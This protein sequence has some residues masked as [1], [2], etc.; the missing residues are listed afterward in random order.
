MVRGSAKYE[1]R[2]LRMAASLT[3]LTAEAEK[4]G[5]TVVMKQ[6]IFRRSLLFHPKDNI[7]FSE[8]EQLFWDGSE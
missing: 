2:R 8:P 3:E 1:A 6:Q 5:I 7:L 4:Y